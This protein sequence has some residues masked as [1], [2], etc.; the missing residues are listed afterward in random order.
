MTEKEIE[1]NYQNDL[2]IDPANIGE[3]LMRQA[4]LYMKYAAAHSNAILVRD[5][6]WEKLKVRRSQLTIE[7]KEKGASNAMLQEAYYRDHKDHKELKEELG[8][9]EYNASML[10]NATA[11][12]SHKRSALE[13][14]VKLINGE[15]YATPKVPK[16][17]KGGPRTV[18]M[19][20]EA[21]AKTSDDQR[22]GL[23]QKKTGREKPKG[24]DQRN[25]RSRGQ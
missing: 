4:G 13:N 19:K 16:D 8:E 1:Y 10:Q 7:A 23:N 22:N 15:W 14:M 3:E 17:L 24:R 9:V 25:P 18:D 6:V 21:S 12:F 5:R 11:A 2:A 20:T